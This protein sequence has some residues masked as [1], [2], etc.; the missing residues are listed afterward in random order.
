MGLVDFAAL[1]YGPNYAVFGVTA[2]LTLP[3]TD[4][5]VISTGADGGPLLVIDKTAGIATATSDRERS[6]FHAE[7]ETVTPAAIVR[8]ADLAS[9]DREDLQEAALVF[10][11]KT[12]RV[13]THGFRPSPNGEGDGEIL[14]YLTER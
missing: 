2:T 10:N 12:W 11:S 6:R 3:G 9:V 4:G 1:L 13:D 14:L 5:A 7:I 8:A